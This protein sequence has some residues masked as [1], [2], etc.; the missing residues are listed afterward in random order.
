M[1]VPPQ[2]HKK[3]PK[4][5]IE[6]DNEEKD[7]DFYYSSYQILDSRFAIE[8]SDKINDNSF[9]NVDKSI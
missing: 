7:K 2:K 9:V 4:L 6:C 3:L 5:L 1:R 8:E